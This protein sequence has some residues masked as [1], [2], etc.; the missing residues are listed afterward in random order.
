MTEIFVGFVWVLSQYS[1]GVMDQVIANRV[2]WG[3]LPASHPVT[4]YVAVEDCE[5]LGQV[6]WLRPLWEAEAEPFLVTDCARQDG[7]DGTLSWMARKRIFAE[8]DAVSATRWGTTGK[9]FYGAVVEGPGPHVPVLV[10]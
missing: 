5:W 1:P 9:L 8:L 4:S 2:R 10:R 6:V 3:Q 7:M